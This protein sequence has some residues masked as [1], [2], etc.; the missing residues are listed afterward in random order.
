MRRA[1]RGRARGRQLVGALRL[2][3]AHMP[4]PPRFSGLSRRRHWGR[5]RAGNKKTAKAKSRKSR[6]AAPSSCSAF[7]SVS[8][9]L[10]RGSHVGDKQP[11]RV[12]LKRTE[13][14]ATMRGRGGGEWRGRARDASS[15]G[16]S[17]DSERGGLPLSFSLCCVTVT[18]RNSALAHVV[19]HYSD[20]E[21]ERER[22]RERE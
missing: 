8:H 19:I 22:E 7:Q 13:T 14:S 4:S 11:L 15:K 10:P 1:A 21:R 5:L 12:R 18:A 9:R 3:P 2:K 16:R 20:S 6:A 17:P